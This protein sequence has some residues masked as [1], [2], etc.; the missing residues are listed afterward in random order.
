MKI[1]L[2][3]LAG[4]LSTRMGT[5]FSKVFFNHH[6]KSIVQYS[7]EPFLQIKQIGQI[8]IVCPEETHAHFQ[9]DF[10]FAL[11]GKER[12]LSLENGLLKCK[13]SVEHVLVHDAARP[14][15]VKEDIEKLINEGKEIGCIVS[16][17]IK[18][19]KR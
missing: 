15:V 5:N 1:A 13:K 10:T 16:T 2:I 4:G 19:A 8:I 18:N 14:L 3:M 17:I 7:L 11:P 6:D 9:G 12:F